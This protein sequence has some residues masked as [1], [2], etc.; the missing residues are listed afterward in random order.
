[1]PPEIVFWTV[2]VI[3]AGGG[4]TL[5]ALISERRKLAN[6]IG[7][8]PRRSI[9]QVADNT[10]ACISGT[11]RSYRDLIG[12]GLT[13]RPCVVYHA[14]VFGPPGETG[15]IRRTLIDEVH[16]AL[17]VLEDE[18]GRALI[19][20]T[21]AVVE[22]KFDSWSTRDTFR[23]RTP[24]TDALLA[25]H[26]FTRPTSFWKSQLWCGEGVI[27]PGDRVTV[28]GLCVRE[29][30][31]DAGTYRDGTALRVRVGGSPGSPLWMTKRR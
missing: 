26:G 22:I 7:R 23:Q 9:A 8:V 13:G 30:D 19:D 25:R 10:R 29:G 1:M 4:G 27:A 28:V 11:V 17:F 16:G 14:Q 24:R 12:A 5:G 31:P 6:K 18:T 21:D 3:L 15:A 20:P 2:Y